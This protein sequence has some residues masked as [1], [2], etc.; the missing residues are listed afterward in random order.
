MR[1]KK[2][3]ECGEGTYQETSIYDDWDGVVHCTE[4]NHVVAN[5]VDEGVDMKEKI[6][7]L[8][9]QAG[10]PFWEDESWGPGPGRIDWSSDCTGELEKFAELLIEECADLARDFAQHFTD[11]DSARFLRSQIMDHFN[12]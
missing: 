9:E 2:C 4:C 7:E 6:T 8:A 1:G 10:F 11:D 12:K 3:L 5:I